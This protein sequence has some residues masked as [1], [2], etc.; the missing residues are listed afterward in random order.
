ME[1][2]AGPAALRRRY[3]DITLWVDH[4]CLDAQPLRGCCS[5][6]TPSCGRPGSRRCAPTSSNTGTLQLVDLGSAVIA[7]RLRAV[8]LLNTY[9]EA[10]RP[11]LTST[12]QGLRLVPLQ[13]AAARRRRRRP[14]RRWRGFRPDDLA[15]LR[16]QFVA[17]LEMTRAR[18]Q[19]AT[20]LTGPHRDD[21]MFLAGQVDLRVFGSRGQQRT[22]PCA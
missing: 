10:I 20:T 12:P 19:Q 4:V 14:R 1:L 15:R 17:R 6:A 22:R 2:I 8:A 11:R 7:A 18:E 5:S 9:I 16:A 3:L 13:R 21:A